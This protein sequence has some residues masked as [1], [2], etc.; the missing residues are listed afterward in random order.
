MKHRK[1]RIAWSVACGIAVVLS[2]LGWVRTRY[3]I[4]MSR[5]GG[6]GITCSFGDPACD[7]TNVVIGS[8]QRNDVEFHCVLRLFSS[9]RNSLITVSAGRPVSPFCMSLTAAL[10][11]ATF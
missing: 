7:V 8:A 9:A 4:D 11:A 3:S 5:H 10:T 2:A 6:V 1:L